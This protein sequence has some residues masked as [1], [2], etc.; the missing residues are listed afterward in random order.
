MNNCPK[1][2]VIIPVYNVENYLE[3]C[4]NS[5][6][7]QTMPDFE[8]IC[9]DDGSTD[10]SCEILTRYARQDARIRVLTQCNQGA[11]AAR[12]YGF[13]YSSGKYTY[14][15]DSD[16]VCSPLLLEKT[17]ETAEREDADIVAFHFT[18]FYE[19]GHETVSV[20]VHV[21]WLPEDLS[22]FNYTDCPD[23]IMSIVNPTPWNKL[24]RSD[25]IR[26][27]GLHFDEISSS[28][29]IA[30]SAV[31]AAT[32]E[33][34]AI[35]PSRLMRYRVGHSGTISSTKPQKLDNI[36]LAVS[37]AVQQASAL[38][39]ADVI[40]K[41]IYRFAIDNFIFALEHNISDFDSP[42]A[43]RYYE[44]IHDYF[45]RSEFDSLQQE[46]LNNDVLYRTFCTVRKH[47]YEAMR[48][49]KARR[50]IV[51]LTTYPA[52]IEGIPSV[53][54]TIYNQTRPA[55]K[56]LLYLAAE[57]FPEREAGLPD[58][59][60]QLVHDGLLTIRWCDDLK[61]HKK[62]FYAMQ[63]YPEDL[64][65]T[66]D[67]DLLYSPQ[68]LERL[69]QSYLLYPTAI[70]AARTH[71]ITLS[72]E[73]TVLPYECWVKETDGCLYTP[74]MQLLATG[75]A[76]ALYPPHLLSDALFNKQVILDTCL[77]ADDLWMKA[78]ELLSNVPV[79]RTQ[80]HEN[81]RYLP[82]SQTDALCHQNISQNQND[83]QWAQISS[84]ADQHY[85]N[86]ILVEKLTKLDIGER[87]LSTEAI[88]RHFSRERME[89]RK[90]V[91]IINSR[92]QRA[93]AEKS[94]LNATLQRTYREKSE[95]NAKLQQ[96]YKEKAERG[97]QIKELR[98]QLKA[99]KK[100]QADLQKQLN[101]TKKQLNAT[102]KQLNQVKKQ[103]KAIKRSLSYRIG[104]ALTWPV[105][106]LKK[107][108]HK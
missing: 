13:L 2:S 94:E 42:I 5:L 61:P 11:G 34:I 68:L 58:A 97:V 28:N 75:G 54:E 44:Y 70:S 103:N 98:A 105:R 78:I 6:L 41:S 80:P 9:V 10:R 57:Q 93:Y 69:Y 71:L 26:K 89:N 7:A 4:L 31:S 43:K 39:Y 56:V 52:R 86:N 1:V 23:L 85:G 101:T 100:A 87:I 99:A 50:L 74:S 49:L 92:L 51:S 27:N 62:Y 66:I 40:Q 76:G 106:K 46:D 25:F 59:L 21:D 90:K 29:D 96:T 60:L 95:I 48:T 22:V 108:L 64:I 88:C 82:G 14:F 63:E 73:G 67:D 91:N 104:R 65:V 55:D 15:F 36:V 24:F 17:V 84:W 33:R 35:V 37:S 107:L 30:F 45:L 77:F 79:V 32:A 72:E 102:K 20:G 47:D 16:D 83:I 38:P 3:D 18:R 81:L 53:L 19:D 8:I 12:N